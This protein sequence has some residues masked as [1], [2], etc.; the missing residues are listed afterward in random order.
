MGRLSFVTAA[1]AALAVAF[2]GGPAAAETTCTYPSAYPGDSAPKE[3]IAAWMAGGAIQAGIPGELPVMA[4]IVESSVT[5]LP[6]G[7]RNTAGYFQMRV[8]IW[9]SGAYQGFPDH[10]PLQLQWFID[11]ALNVRKQAYANGNTSY[12]AD[13]S[14]WGAWV[15]DV[16][17]P[18]QQYRGQYQPKLPDAQA[19]IA[20]GRTC[21]DASTGSPD[22]PPPSDEAPAAGPPD[23]QAIPDSVLPAL[24][25]SVRRFQNAGQT[26]KLVAKARCSNEPCLLRAAAAVAIP[27]HGSFRLSV[28]PVRF[29]K[30]ATATFRLVLSKRQR[31]L[32][33]TSI[34][35]GRCPLGAIRVVAANDGGW[36]YSQSRTVWL[37][38][39]GSC[40]G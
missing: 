21:T 25:M 14:T 33:T 40:R 29:A 35:N 36:R 32:V 11:Q 8:D 28:Q 10:P 7:D 12:G 30:S 9:N 24:I 18:P 2:A 34:R 16:E 22:Q 37:G 23:A 6:Q 38:R 39:R 20:K 5:N 13:S 31:K 19:L 15:A 17:R 1:I 3:Q 26:G 27:N 4:A